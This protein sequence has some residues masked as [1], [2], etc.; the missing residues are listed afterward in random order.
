MN[1]KEFFKT[2]VLDKLTVAKF[3]DIEISLIERMMEDYANQSKWISVEERLPKER[4][5]RISDD[6]IVTDGKDTWQDCYD[7]DFSQWCKLKYQSN[8]IA[9]QPLPIFNQ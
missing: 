6:V 8:V 2:N 1:A 9:W 3:T 4:V 7:Y 5:M